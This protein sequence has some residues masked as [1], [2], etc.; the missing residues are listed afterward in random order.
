M[1]H[2]VIA[3]SGSSREPS[4]TKAPSFAGR[5]TASAVASRTKQ[6]NRK[7]GTKAEIALRR[8]LWGR[9]LR[10]RVHRNDLPG[11]PDL[12][13]R[14]RRVAV[15]VDGDFWHGRDWEERRERLRSGHNAP[16][17]LAKITY[18][19]DRDIRNNTLLSELGWRVLRLWETD[20]LKDPDSA[21][22]L[23]ADA[24]GAEPAC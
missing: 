2:S 19:R 22:R 21:A 23:V 4:L 8:A 13:F 10:Y 7:V 3:L 12:V 15:F 20:V 24:L 1:T 18:N 5:R 11:C 14:R 16:Y 6:R 17:W 9:G